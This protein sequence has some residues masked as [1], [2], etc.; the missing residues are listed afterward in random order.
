MTLR[1]SL[2]P[3]TTTTDQ[4][5]NLVLDAIL[6]GEI[7]TGELIREAVVARQ[8]GISRGPLRE[9][10]SRLEGAQLVERIPGIGPRVIELSRQDLI[11]LFEI[12]GS[13][14]GLAC[15]LATSRLSDTQISELKHLVESQSVHHN[16]NP[17]GKYPYTTDDDFHLLI[18][19]A[20]GNERLTKMLS[21]DLY[22]Q[23]RLYRH[24]SARSSANRLKAAMAEHRKIVAALEA[25]DAD[26]AERAMREHIDYAMA[27]LLISTEGTLAPTQTNPKSRFARTA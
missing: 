19:R 27:S 25:R 18:A 7:D 12:R 8:L 10:L 23:V 15:R 9:A 22:F 26:A 6:Q 3:R 2:Q 17:T 5:F 11:G 16:S 20:C 1:S 4:V 21:K 14:E 13:L 24:R